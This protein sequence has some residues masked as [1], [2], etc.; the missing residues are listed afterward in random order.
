MVQSN[1]DKKKKD[2][3]QLGQ[4]YDPNSIEEKMKKM[5]FA[6]KDDL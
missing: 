3:F 6:K 4:G 5:K 2:N 1:F